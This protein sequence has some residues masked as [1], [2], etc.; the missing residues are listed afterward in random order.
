M[1][2][3]ETVEYAIPSRARADTLVAKTLPLL[4]RLGIPGHRI[5]VFVTEPEINDYIATI[6]TA[7]L[8][9]EIIDGINVERGA[10]GM[11]AQRNRIHEFYGEDVRFVTLDDDLRDIQVRAGSKLAPIDPLQWE[12]IVEEGFRICDLTHARIWG[13][14]PV[15]N[16]F[17]MKPRV[18][19]D[20]CYIGGGLFGVVNRTKD[21][22]LLSELEYRDDWE[23]SVKCY[24]LDGAVVRFDYVTWR[25]EGYRGH[26]GMQTEGDRTYEATLRDCKELVRRYPGLVTLNLTKKSGWPETRLRDPFARKRTA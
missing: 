22:A 21:G 7:D 24:V 18:R 15:A 13:L 20:L 9:S 8:P 25:T 1:S 10:A 12:D 11:C 4:Y 23:R 14:Y 26:G 5:R 3:S 16:G 17:F 6:S 2:I 19:T